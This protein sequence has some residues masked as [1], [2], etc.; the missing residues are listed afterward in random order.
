MVLREVLTSWVGIGSI[1]TVS[2]RAR[3]F[4]DK[5]H[6]WH[7]PTAMVWRKGDLPHLRLLLLHRTTGASVQVVG[8]EVR[9]TRI[10]GIDPISKIAVFG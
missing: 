7:L 9:R 4:L 3:A 6:C 2:D 5:H 1:T 10:R 8:H